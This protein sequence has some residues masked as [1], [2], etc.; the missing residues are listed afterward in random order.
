M[1]LDALQSQFIQFYD[2][3][4]AIVIEQSQKIKMQYPILS[5]IDTRIAATVLA[6]ISAC[7]APLATGGGIALG[8]FGM[9]RYPHLLNN[10]KQIESIATTEIKVIAAALAVLLF[11]SYAGFMLPIGIGIAAGVLLAG[12]NDRLTKR[13]MPQEVENLAPAVQKENPVLKE[14]IVP[15]E[16]PPGEPRVRQPMHPIIQVAREVNVPEVKGRGLPQMPEIPQ[17]PVGV[18]ANRVVAQEMKQAEDA[19]NL[20]EQPY[21]L[22]FDYGW[23]LNPFK[24]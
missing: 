17:P 21:T 11:Y 6:L 14:V 9:E 13:T 4:S 20:Q 1:S 22:T 3:I 24:A 7:V 12:A 2:G 16:S 10:V 15:G 19:D 18:P 5:Q 23:L 8:L